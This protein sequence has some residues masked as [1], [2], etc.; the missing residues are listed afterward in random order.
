MG[1]LGKNKQTLQNEAPTNSPRSQAYEPQRHGPLWR[2]GSTDWSWI[3][4]CTIAFTEWT[5]APF[6]LDSILCASVQS[7]LVRLFCYSLV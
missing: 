7:I 4:G 1:M 2:R 3:T 6:G 5:G